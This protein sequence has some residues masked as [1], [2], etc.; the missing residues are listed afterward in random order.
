M[1]LTISVDD[2]NMVGRKE[3]LAPT[4]AKLRKK[5][6]L[7]DASPLVDQVFLGCSQRAATVDEESIKTKTELF[8]INTTS[9][10]DET[11]KWNAAHDVK[12]VSCCGFE[13]TGRA[14]LC[15]E[16]LCESAPKPA[17]Q[18]QQAETLCID[19]HQLKKEDFD[20]VVEHASVCAQ[21]VQTCLCIASG[22]RATSCGQ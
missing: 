5:I 19:D 2:I 15:V 8:Q 17:S 16:R 3:S 9:G 21:I 4:D 10:K 13:M 6:D 1:L 20:V 22:G 7:E 11:P 14:D 12:R 18:L